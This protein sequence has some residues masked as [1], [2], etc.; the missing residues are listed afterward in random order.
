MFPTE[1]LQNS[2]LKKK[3]RS[4]FR[5]LRLYITIIFC[6][7]GIE[8]SA[9]VLQPL[10]F[11]GGKNFIGK[12]VIQFELG[13]TLEKPFNS[14]ISNDIDWAQYAMF[15]Y[16]INQNLDFSFGYNFSE[17]PNLKSDQ[18]RRTNGISDFSI[19]FKR[20]VSKNL[21][22]K[23]D[24]GISKS[25]MSE[26]LM[27]FQLLGISEHQ[28]DE[29]LSWENNLGL[30]WNF[31]DPK[32]NLAYLSSLNFRMARTLDVTLEFYGQYNP[33]QT[34]NYANFGLGYFFSQDFKIETFVGYGNTSNEQTIFGSIN[35]YFR[36]VPVRYIKET[37]A[38]GEE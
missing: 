11:S 30:R 2:G 33:V 20:F 16:G 29:F 15:K 3:H 38:K 21:S 7:L 23:S 24:L 6:I 28:I 19:G 36:L 22:I 17:E 25:E 32:T 31:D 8:S 1:S 13:S 14:L 5:I 27:A 9:Q 37:V 26:T 34:Y 35:L 18:I 4:N 12:D 10:I